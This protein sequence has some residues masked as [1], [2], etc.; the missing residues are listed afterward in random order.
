MRIE[1]V[2]ALL[3]SNS[4]NSTASEWRLFSMHAWVQKNSRS[5]WV[6]F[7]VDV[8][9]LLFIISSSSLSSSLAIGHCSNYIIWANHLLGW[10][11]YGIHWIFVE[12]DNTDSRTPWNSIPTV[13]CFWNCWMILRTIQS[14][15]A[16]RMPSAE[17]CCRRMRQSNQKLIHL[18]EINEKHKTLSN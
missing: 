15:T 11:C 10:I 2:C 1:N 14:N 6:E 4:S 12:I 17:K 9:R 8:S 13:P 7:V 5:L 3:I 16:N 18:F